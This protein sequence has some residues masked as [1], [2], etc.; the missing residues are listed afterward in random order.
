ML[1]LWFLTAAL[2][3]LGSGLAPPGDEQEVKFSDCPAAVR[4]TFQAE[5]RGAQIQTV[6]KEKDEEETVYWAEVAIRGRTYAIGVLEDGTLAEMN[7]AVDDEELPLDRCPAAVQ[8]TFRREAFGEKLGVVGRDRKY[9][10]LVY[11]TVVHH[12]GRSYEIVVA[13]DG[14]LVEKVLKIDDEPVELAQCPAPVQ[15]T[16]REHAKGGMIGDITRSTGIGPHT[17]EAEVQIN[18]KIYSIEVDQS[19]LLISKSL[20]AGE[21]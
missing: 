18:R 7:L 4:K 8:A 20:Q 19:G 6:T 13:E 3:S 21:E 14:T 1:P 11:E 2:L 12:K 10:V 17:F 5:A 16:L 15:A 9:G